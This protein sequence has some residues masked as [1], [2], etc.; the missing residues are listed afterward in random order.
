ATL[1]TMSEGLIFIGPGDEIRRINSRAAELLGVSARA[2]AGRSFAVLDPPPLLR[3]TL[4]RREELIEQELLWQSQKGAAAILCS[5]RPVFDRARRY[6]GALIIMRP[7]QSVHLLVQRV[8]GARARF[9]FRD[10]IG[11][12]PAMLQALHQAHTAASA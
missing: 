4:Q 2:V 3:L 7:P 10:I 5:V 8:V 6:L 11:Q 12:S 9:T 1:E